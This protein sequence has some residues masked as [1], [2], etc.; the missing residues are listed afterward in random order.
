MM[1]PLLLLRKEIDEGHKTLIG[2]KASALWEM[3]SSGLRVPDFLVLTTAAYER[4]VEINGLKGRIALEFTRK[5]FDEMRWEEIW[6]TALRI[7]NMF[8]RATMPP[9]L[10]QLIISGT[11]E[12][13]EPRLSL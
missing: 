9:E 2:G 10:G 11:K 1:Y 12:I 3:Y 8:S 5:S 6:D 4:F 13:L 7:R